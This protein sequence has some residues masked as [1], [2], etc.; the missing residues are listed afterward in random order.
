M[1]KMYMVL[2]LLRHCLCTIIFIRGPHHLS[3]VEDIEPI[4]QSKR[5]WIQHLVLYFVVFLVQRIEIG[6]TYDMIL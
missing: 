2:Y 5:Y 1:L 6:G 3:V 4:L